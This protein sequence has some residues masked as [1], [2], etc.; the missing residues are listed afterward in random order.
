MA[1]KGIVMNGITVG[2]LMHLLEAYPR[3]MEVFQFDFDTYYGY[4]PATG[5]RVVTL[6]DHADPEHEGKKVLCVVERMSD[7]L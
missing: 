3:D 5:V 6:D 4:E 7:W 1:E 2:Q